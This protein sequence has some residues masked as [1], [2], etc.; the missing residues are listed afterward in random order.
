MDSQIIV[1]D[2]LKVLGDMPSDSINCCVTSPP[3][4]NLRQYGVDSEI[5]SEVTPWEYI[6]RLVN[7][8]G[9]VFR[10]LHPR[11]TFW[12]NLGDAYAQDKKWGGTTGGKHAKGLHR[13]TGIGRNRTNTGL[14]SKSLIGLPWRV[15]LALQERGWRIRADIIWNKPN[16]MPH[17]VKDRPSVSHEYIF[18]LTKS[19]RYFYDIDAIREPHSETSLERRD[20]GRSG[21]HKSDGGPGNHTLARNLDKSCH[22]NGRNR[23]SVWSVSVGKYAGSH[24]AT[25]PPN[26]ITPCILAGCPRG[27]IVLD[28]FGGSG[29]TGQ[30]ANALGR[31]YVLIEVNPNYVELIKQRVNTPLRK[32]TNVKGKKRR[33][34]ISQLELFDS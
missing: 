5:G 28:P 20:R 12:L 17:P 8:F 1:G 29:T 18:L 24:F 22:P 3:Y 2:C 9:Q 6:D 7:V 13:T 23:R 25:F 30:V 15:A 32:N 27:G 33:K 19:E 10:V 4:W 31:R 21:R 34:A 14:P 16:A 26:L 11:G